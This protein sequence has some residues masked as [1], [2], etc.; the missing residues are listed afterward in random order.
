MNKGNLALI[1]F[2]LALAKAVRPE[3][4]HWQPFVLKLCVKTVKNLNINKNEG[5]S[6]KGQG[7]SLYLTLEISSRETRNRL[8]R[9]T[10]VL[11]SGKNFKCSKYILCLGKIL[12]V[13]RKIQVDRI[14]RKIKHTNKIS[15][16]N[17][18]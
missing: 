4:S 5:N 14:S 3:K 11:V 18:L 8:Q 12:N 13:E 15:P 2:K 17:G 1:A 6:C 10:S 7:Q 9:T 16:V